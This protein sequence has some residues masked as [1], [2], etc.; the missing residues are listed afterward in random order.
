MACVQKKLATLDGQCPRPGR[1]I[2]VVDPV[3]I[4]NPY[5]LLLKIHRQAMVIT[6][7]KENMKPMVYGPLAFDR[8]DPV[9]QG[10][11]AIARTRTAR[12]R[13]RHPTVHA[14]SKSRYLD[15]ERTHLDSERARTS[16]GYTYLKGK[17]ANPWSVRAHPRLES[18]HTRSEHRRSSSEPARTCLKRMHTRP[19]SA[20]L[21]NRTRGSAAAAQT[22]GASRRS[23]GCEPRNYGVHAHSFF[24]EFRVTLLHGS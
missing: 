2:I 24:R 4:D 5:W 3:Y 21:E 16:S 18:M 19:E 8:N 10:V 13:Y 20:G 17:S 7:D 15:H 22:P 6:R 12:S 23:C 14:R 1:P 11:E 9:N